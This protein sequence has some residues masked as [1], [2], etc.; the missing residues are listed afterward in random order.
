MGVW[1][2]FF[3]GILFLRPALGAIDAFAPIYSHRNLDENSPLPITQGQPPLGTY[4]S[5]PQIVI[6]AAQMGG[7]YEPQTLLNIGQDVFVDNGRRAEETEFAHSSALLN[8]ELLDTAE[9]EKDHVRRRSESG[10]FIV[11]GVRAHFPEGHER[12]FFF[13]NGVVV[14]GQFTVHELEDHRNPIVRDFRETF[15]ALE[16]V[17]IDLENAGFD[18]AIPRWLRPQL[19]WLSLVSGYENRYQAV[20]AELVRLIQPLPLQHLEL[21]GFDFGHGEEASLF[22]MLRSRKFAGRKN[23]RELVLNQVLFVEAASFLQFLRLFP[24]L[25][26]LTLNDVQVRP[27]GRYVFV[28]ERL[29]ASHI[30]AIGTTVERAD[31]GRILPKLRRL[32]VNNL[33]NRTTGPNL[34]LPL[35]FPQTPFANLTHLTLA[36][37]DIPRDF[38]PEFQQMASELETPLRYLDLGDERDYTFSR[39]DLHEGTLPY[40]IVENLHH[41]DL[42]GRL[43]DDDL[44]EWLRGAPQLNL[45]GLHLNENRG[46]TDDSLKYIVRSKKFSQ[47]HILGFGSTNVTPAGVRAVAGMS[48]LKRFTWLDMSLRRPTHSGD[49]VAHLVRRGNIDDIVRWRLRNWQLSEKDLIAILSKPFPKLNEIYVTE[50]DQFPAEVLRRA[51]RPLEDRGVKVVVEEG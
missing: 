37:S 45:R 36:N 23:V 44:S 48:G 50:S 10:R 20:S 16:I 33:I 15:G 27:M 35:V 13:R 9:E 19:H 5:C 29:R 51:L 40:W 32:Y 2:T 11:G 41:L 47:L 18:R 21:T 8:H 4:R 34:S 22:N 3:W 42:S 31:V 30:A 26:T 7:A 46:F 25:E 6:L 43:W 1:K 17:D 24:N 12:S 28:P 39:F 14:G 38:F 49:S